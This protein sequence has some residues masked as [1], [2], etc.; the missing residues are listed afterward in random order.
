MFEAMVMPGCL[1]AMVMPGC[2]NVMAVLEF[3]GPYACR[4]H[5]S[6]GL[7]CLKLYRIAVTDENYSLY[8]NTL[9]HNTLYCSLDFIHATD[10]L[11]FLLNE[12]V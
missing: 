9:Y 1:S 7:C 3:S 8:H 4:H 2:S 12:F 5:C 11:P 10:L 6:R